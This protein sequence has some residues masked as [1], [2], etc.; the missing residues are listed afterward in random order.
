MHRRLFWI[1]LVFLTLTD[2]IFCIYRLVFATLLD[3]GRACHVFLDGVVYLEMLICLIEVHI[4]A[5]FMAACFQSTRI[6]VFL[7]RV[8][9]GIFPLGALLVFI[10]EQEIHAASPQGSSAQSLV[11]N[12]SWAIIVL[13]L[14]SI[15]TILYAICV[16]K[17]AGAPTEIKRRA[18]LRGFTYELNFVLT[19]GSRAI[20][21]FWSDVPVIVGRFSLDLIALNGSLNVMTYMFWM[22][23]SR[24]L[25][26]R[27]VTEAPALE[28]LVIDRYFDLDLCSDEFLLDVQRQTA[29]CVASLQEIR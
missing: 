2:S 6:Q 28:Q 5:G 27:A 12:C 29:L 13:S 26:A 8:L 9:P 1:Q 17:T 19:F 20:L 11:K 4:A 7:R 3:A 25:S 10:Q 22:R 14:C 16:V 23:R 24:K 15:A 18:L 21:T